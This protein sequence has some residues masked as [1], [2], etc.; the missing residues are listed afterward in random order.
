M[1]IFTIMI[2]RKTLVINIVAMM[3]LISLL[4]IYIFFLIIMITTMYMVLSMIIIASS[5]V[6]S[7]IRIM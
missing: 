7:P 4:Q 1:A 6:D 2:T 5:N 3:K